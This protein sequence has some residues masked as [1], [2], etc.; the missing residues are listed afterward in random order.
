M[1]HRTKAVRAAAIIKEQAMSAIA[2]AITRLR[3]HPRADL[4]ELHLL[5]VNA[6]LD[7]IIR[8]LVGNTQAATLKRGGPRR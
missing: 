1:S 2:S 3:G 8:Q 4:F 6:Q 7:I 5:G